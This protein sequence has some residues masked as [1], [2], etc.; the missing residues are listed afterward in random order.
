MSLNQHLP[1][2]ECASMAALLPLAAHNLLSEQETARLQTHLA[3][4]AHCRAELALD[5]QIEGSLR[6]SYAPSEDGRPLW[7]RQEITALLSAP[8]APKASAA[9]QQTRTAPPVIP[10]ASE[11]PSRRWLGGLPAL[12]ATLVIILLAVAIFGIPGLFPGLHK[13]AAQLPNLSGITL[14]SISMVSA[15]EGWAVGSPNRSLQ[16]VPPPTGSRSNGPSIILHYHNG[17]WTEQALPAE[18]SNPQGDYVLR[19]VSMVSATE[20]W[21]VGSTVLPANVDG[22]T[23]GILL[24]YTGGRWTRVTN[25]PLGAQL[26]RVVM[27]SATDGWIVGE[28]QANDPNGYMLVL[29]YDGHVWQ[30]IEALAFANQPWFLQSV[31]ES[32]NG[33]V[34]I[35]GFSLVELQDTCIDKATPGVLFHYDGS[36]WTSQT[37][38]PG[39]NLFAVTMV[40]A[41]EGWAVGFQQGGILPGSNCVTDSSKPDQGIIMHYQDGQWQEAAQIAGDGKT[42]YFTLSGLAMVS[43]DEGWAV[44]SEGTIVHYHNGVWTRVASPI[45]Q[46]GGTLYSVAMVSA[47]E[48]WA[49]GEYGTILHYHN[50]AWSIVANTLPR[51]APTATPH[52]NLSQ[53]SLHDIA[54]VSPTEGWAV[55]NTWTMAG[56]GSNSVRVDGGDP[57]ILH[58]QSGRW[59]TQPLPDF[60]SHFG[61]S[62]RPTICPMVR[63]GSISMLSVREGWAVGSTVLRPGADG[64]TLPILLHYIG[65]KWTW[66]DLPGDA[67]SRIYMRSATD[68]WMLKGFFNGGGQSIALHYDGHSWTPVSD[69]LFAGIAPMTLAET[70]DGQVWISGVDYNGQVGEDGNEPAVLLHYDGQR[71]SKIDPHV[72]NARLEG[73]FFGSPDEGWAVGTLPNNQWGAAYEVGGLILHYV[74]G[75]WQRQELFKDPLSSQSL[76]SF[77][78]VAMVSPDEGWAVGDEG[79]ILH[80][81]N[82]T[83]GEF[84]NPTGQTLYSV[85]MVSPDE[86][87]A[88]G[89]GVIVHYQGGSWRVYNG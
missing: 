24:H 49:V 84:Q 42:R 60:K 46:E 52:L 25:A 64:I 3:T 27:R 69:P 14:T 20:G 29:H 32:P 36:R 17:Q 10:G 41:S 38:T 86:G 5:A 39:I 83:W 12:A 45:A 30:R 62:A 70:P 56:T 77:Y 33:E 89:D 50:G 43:P 58:Y 16:N 6:R 40:S 55:G 23:E 21:A 79:V 65:G 82:G 26:L 87:W 72:A 81:H 68:G 11:P 28:G 85:V 54:M 8:A 44:G 88:V 51:I 18:L 67:V 13:S 74:N 75:V 59:T 4:C 37:I 7:S 19:S 63:L 57:V 80:Y 73:L 31:V 35:S 53:Y 2:R 34:W 71:W 48:G 61:C 22:V 9:A 47:T 66:V 76:F 15:N 1:T 78:S